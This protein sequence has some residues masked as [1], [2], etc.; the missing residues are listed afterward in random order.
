[1]FSI[2]G[3]P[4]SV[5]TASEKAEA[6]DGEIEDAKMTDAPPTEDTASTPVRPPEGAAAEF[7]KDMTESGHVD[8]RKQSPALELG[9]SSRNPE[10]PTS[11]PGV[12]PTP[13]PPS[14]QSSTTSRPDILRNSSSTSVNGRLQHNLPTKPD[15]PPPRAGDHRMPPRASDRGLPDYVRDPRFPER[16]ASRELLRDRDPNRSASGP[17][18]YVHERPSDRAQPTE[19]DRMDIRYGSEKIPPGR[20]GIEDRYGAPNARDTRPLHRDDRSERPPLDRPYHEQHQ[21]RRETEVSRAHARDSAMPP[22]RSNIPQHPDR[23]ALIHGSQSS[24]RAQPNDRRPEPAR[25]DNYSHLERSSRGPSPTRVDDRRPPRYDGRRDDRP[26]DGH[27]SVEDLARPNAAR[28]DEPHAPTGPRTGRPAN[29]APLTSNDR[30][31]ESMKPSPVAPPLDPNHGR[32]SNDSSLGNRHGESQYGRLNADGDIPSGPRLP[33]GSHPSGRGGRNVSAPQSQLNTQLPASYNQA[34]ATPAQDR[35]TPSGPSMRGSPRKPGPFP[36]AAAPSSAPSTPVIETAGI[37]PDR[38]KA[39]QSSGVGTADSASQI[40]GDPARGPR[41]P[42]PPVSMP[43]SGP[44]RGPG[45][46]LPSPVGPSGATRGPP[47]G[48]AMPNDRNGRDKRFAGLQNVLQQGAV[49]NA[50]E[51]SG[52]GASIRGRGGRANNANVP[53]PSTSGPPTPGL[54]RQDQLP[55]QDLLAGRPNGPT[56]LQ[57][58]GDDAAYGRGRRVGP[59]ELPREAERRSGRYRSRS[60]GKERAPGASMRARDEEL[61][62]RDGARER[63]RGNEALLERDGRGAGPPEASIRGA[64][65]RDRGPPRE[66]RRSGREEPQYRER[67][68]RDGPERRDERDRRDGGGSGRKRGRGG[69]EGLGERNFSDSKRARR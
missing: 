46:Q 32:L 8:P 12:R 48:P 63:P 67:D 7:S 41:P 45:N 53:S 47:T 49:P 24:D 37:H 62:P 4:Q 34:S 36:P 28:L 58:S 5:G 17:H 30:F 31:R 39:I 52:Q 54:P 3:P 68:Q 60:P 33:N 44:S 9:Q 14:T 57:Q 40:R 50:P 66:T 10:P 25:Q 1:M 56:T 22:P 69:D 29:V 21:S 27:R 2:N 38:L 15:V 64:D 61:P 20:T 55:S 11:K 6:E 16:G 35:P 59:R 51:R 42:P 19:K 18:P 26:P 23:A 65:S 13:T 43:A